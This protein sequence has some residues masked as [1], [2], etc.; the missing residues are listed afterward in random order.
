MCLRQRSRLLT[1]VWLRGFAGVEPSPRQRLGAKRSSFYP[2]SHRSRTPIVMVESHGLILPELGLEA[3]RVP[4][5]GKLASVASNSDEHCGQE[6]QSS[7]G[8]LLCCFQKTWS[9]MD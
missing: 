3:R 5:A 6:R 9:I 4:R 7:R 8:K 2:K 1:V